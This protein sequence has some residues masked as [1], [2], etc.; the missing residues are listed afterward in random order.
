MTSIMSADQR[1][2]LQEAAAT[3]AETLERDTAK[4]PPVEGQAPVAIPKAPAVPS[5]EAGAA[6]SKAEEK[7]KAEEKSSAPAAEPAAE[8][9]EKEAQAG[10]AAPIAA[11]APA[12]SLWELVPFVLL[13]ASVFWALR[14]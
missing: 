2:V 4:P 5:L 6:P 8:A 11:P 1:R 10:A 13:A 14:S 12:G 3:G 9:A 7:T